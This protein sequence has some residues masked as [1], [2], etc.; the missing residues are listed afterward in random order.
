MKTINQL[1]CT[2]LFFTLSQTLIAQSGPWAKYDQELKDG[3]LYREASQ[4]NLEE[5]KSIIQGGGNIH[6][7]SSQTKYTILMAAAGSG[8]IEVVRYILSL[9]VDPAVKDWWDQ[10][11]VDKARSVG[12][13]DIV[14]LLQ[15]VQKG[16]T[17][18]SEGK[19]EEEEKQPE[20]KKPVLEKPPVPAKPG[21]TTWPPFGSYNVGDSIIYWEPTGWRTGVIKELG[22]SKRIGKISV[23]FSERKYLIDPDAYALGNDWY[24]WTGVVKTVRQPFWTDWFI[25]EWQI[26][27]VQAHHNEVKN[28]KETD[29]YYYMGAT[30]ILKV[31]KN[32]SYSWKLIDGKIKTG[33]WVPASNQP[34]IVLK[35]AYR[36]FDWTLRNATSIHDLYIRKLDI[37]DLKPSAVVG[38]TLGYRKTTL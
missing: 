12:A 16:N 18:P 19:Q 33:K 23:D 37:I 21:P 13:N 27:E 28:G 30:E 29:T 17:P 4:G 3:A 6:Y 11:A 25:G 1:I 24:E 22:V 34:G 20:E 36:D 5:V 35:R 15:Q 9:G 31:F 8:K 7:K 14:Q 26:G 32:G 10:T 38:G 2:F